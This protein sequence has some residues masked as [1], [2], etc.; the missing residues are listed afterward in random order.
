MTTEGERRFPL[1]AHGAQR[2]ASEQSYERVV[3]YDAERQL[4]LDA[5]GVPL[6][7]PGKRTALPGTRKTA[8]YV[9]TTDDE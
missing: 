3:R 4:T 8:V 1:L 9:E 2:L 6:H 7:H 5:D